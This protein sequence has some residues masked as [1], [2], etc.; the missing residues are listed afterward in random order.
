MFNF[1][2][3]LILTCATTFIAAA[4]AKG[5]DEKWPVHS[6]E[7]PRPPVVTP[8]P[9]GAPVPAPADAIM[10]FDGKDLSL[11]KQQ[12]TKEGEED[13]ARWNLAEDYMEVVSGTGQHVC[14]KIL[15]GDIQLHIEWATPKEVKGK[16]QGRGNSGIFID[17][18]PEVQVLDSYENDT[19]PD[20]QAGGLYGQF[21]PLVN[22][23]R[24]P[25][26]WQTY[27]IIIER[28]IVKEGEL[29]RKARLTVIQNGVVIQAGREFNNRTTEG[30]L[31]MQDHG[32]PVR[33]RNIWYRTLQPTK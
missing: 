29:M 2:R 24:P 15:A 6:M 22:A 4:D 31:S 1:N 8:A 14:R 20:G 17:G 9:G 5:P 7:R 26:E 23:C 30:T 16:G 12:K 32:N 27:D 19:Y 13:T 10:L 28:A 11:W 25:G 3:L 18:F 21:P 33:F